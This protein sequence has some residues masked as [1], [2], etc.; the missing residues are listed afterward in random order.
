MRLA[1]SM[2]EVEL[3][4]LLPGVTASTSPTDY[5]PLKH[6]QMKRFNGQ[7]WDSIDTLSGR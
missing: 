5:E 7:T 2:N 6:L 3:P 1:T 4:M